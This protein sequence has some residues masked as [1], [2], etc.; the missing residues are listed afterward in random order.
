MYPPGEGKN[1]KGD[2]ILDEETQCFMSSGGVSL[3]N[4]GNTGRLPP[5]QA[6]WRKRKHCSFAYT[7][8]IIM[9]AG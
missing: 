9:I 8:N 7:T 2:I 6:T 1:M 3:A 5:V 4:P